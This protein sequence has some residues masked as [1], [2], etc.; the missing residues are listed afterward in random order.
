MT[1]QSKLLD[2]LNPE[3]KSAVIF[4]GSSVLLISGAGSGKT[5]TIVSKIAYLISEKKVTPGHIL[6]VTF[7]NKAAKEMSKRLWSL[8]INTK[9]LWIGTFHSICNKLL[10]L[11]YEAANLSKYFSIMDMQDQHSFLKRVI[12]NNKLDPKIVGSNR[13]QDFINQSK[14]KGLRPSSF[15]KI[16][17]DVQLYDAYEKECQRVGCIDFAELLLRAYELLEKNQ[18][19]LEYYSNKFHYI[20]VDEFQDTNKLQYKWLKLLSIKHKNIFAVGD[21]DQSIYSFRGA[22]PQNMVLFKKDFNAKIIKLEQNYRST[23]HILGAANK[24]ININKIRQ[25]KNLWTTEGDGEPIK[26]FVGFNEEIEASFIIEQ[27]KKYNKAGLNYRDMAIL[28]RTN[29]QSRNLEKMFTINKIPFIV[30][31]GFRFF[32]RQEVKHAMAYLKLVHNLADN[33]ALSRI[34][35]IPN[36]KIG[37]TTLKKIN[38]YALL[39]NISMWESLDK[40]PK[41]KEKTQ[42]FIDLIKNLQTQISSISLP[43]QV[44]LIIEESGLLDLYKKEGNDG[45]ERLDNLYE[46]IS[47][48]EIFTQENQNGNIDDFLNYAV[49]ETDVSTNKR[50]ESLDQVKFMTVHAAKGLEFEL[51]FVTGL[52]E[53][54]FPH[55]NSIGDNFLIEEERR[56]MYVS[57]TRA[58]KHL[59]ITHTEERMLRGMREMMFPSRFLKEIPKEHF[60]RIN[61]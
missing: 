55:A 26:G 4:E 15:D 21:D 14:E 25:G 38:D 10:K 7:T 17:Q 9:D 2:T 58:K 61:Y 6:A 39:N 32:D 43:R 18:D 1:S 59:F 56:L 19:L 48:A 47:A 54:L 45:L 23:G 44:E 57:I 5:K 29:A 33:L 50:D 24:I 30:Y 34:I 28:Y 11:N 22:E 31:G 53:G 8:N 42:D 12:R 13:V 16:T 49:L 35:N 52:E 3:Q 60:Y 41:V 51:V 37:E 40:V 27:I 20:L 46:L 36:R